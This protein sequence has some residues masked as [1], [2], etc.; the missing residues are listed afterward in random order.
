[1]SPFQRAIRWFYWILGFVVG[2]TFAAA[3]FFARLMIRPP[4]QRLWTTPHEVGLPYTEV[5]FPARDGVR[6]S[7]WL[8]P[9]ASPNGDG[10]TEKRPA[11]ILVHGWPWN[12]LGSIGEGLLA[13]IMR[14]SPVEFL[15]LAYALHYAGYHLL[16]F[17][18]RN[19]GRSAA[20]PPVSFGL[21]EANDLLGALD[22]LDGRLGVDHQRI[23]VIGFS[24]GAN[25]I[26]HALPRTRQIRA[27]VCV[28]PT[29]PTIFARGYGAALMGP[30]SQ[31]VQPIA[32]MFYQAAG[33][34]RLSALDPIFAASS[35]GPTPILYVQ[36]QGDRWGSVDNVLRMAAVTP[37]A[38]EP[39][40][41]RSEGRFGG[42][43]YVI[44]HPEVILRFLEA[45]MTS[46]IS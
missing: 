15:R 12:R 20:A 36:G 30:F 42:Y 23:G 33:G 2:L 41:V 9:A 3:G 18:L 31:L 27:A 11:V 6:L 25:T 1:M 39:L 37:Q 13:A 19:H 28:Q 24:M 35:A 26:L 34:L 16:L 40:I 43:Q 14:S 10:Q 46:T 5:E 32:E 21:L 38:A 17:D 45:E 29:S 22:Y 44:E 4:R 7:G 8:I